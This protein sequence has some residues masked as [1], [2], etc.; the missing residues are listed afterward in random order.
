VFTS[1]QYN[2]QCRYQSINIQQGLVN[3]TGTQPTISI[4][5]LH[6]GF[7]DLAKWAT[8]EE[9]ME[10]CKKEELATDEERKIIAAKTMKRHKRNLRAKVMNDA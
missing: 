8:N 3:G 7:R 10:A 4:Q 9:V 2:V 6:P 1:V 5:K